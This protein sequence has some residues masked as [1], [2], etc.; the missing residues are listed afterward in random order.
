MFNETTAVAS[1]LAFF[2]RA[3]AREQVIAAAREKARIEMK[4]AIKK[5]QPALNPSYAKPPR[6]KAGDY[7]VTPTPEELALFDKAD[8]ERWTLKQ[9]A[10]ALGWSVSKVWTLRTERD[11]QRRVRRPKAHRAKY[12]PGHG[13]PPPP[14]TELANGRRTLILTPEQV[15]YFGHAVDTTE[16]I[17]TVCGRLGISKKTFYQWRLHYWHDRNFLRDRMKETEQLEAARS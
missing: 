16:H 5:M 2:E 7:K 8:A 14:V 3:I 9:I 11:H 15:E 4:G 12:G 6:V 17:D 10:A 1:C 13:K